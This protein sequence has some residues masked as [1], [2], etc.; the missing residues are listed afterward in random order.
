MIHQFCFMHQK[1]RHHSTTRRH[2]QAT[3]ATMTLPSNQESSSH[4]CST[5]S[6]TRT[7]TTK[8]VKFSEKVKARTTTHL[9]S[10][11]PEEKQAYWYTSDEIKE[12][13]EDIRA[14]LKLME[15]EMDLSSSQEFCTRGL[16]GQIREV[17]RRRSDKKRRIWLALLAEQEDQ[18]KRGRYSEQS[19]ADIYSAEVEESMMSALIIGLIDEQQERLYMPTLKDSKNLKKDCDSLAVISYDLRGGGDGRPSCSAAL[20]LLQSALHH[21]HMSTH[22]A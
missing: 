11:T 9:K 22:A 1:L 19:L 13:R 20:L 4:S 14:T 6:T 8:S 5:T 7:R 15:M 2:K 12:I 10:F 18:Y 3:T 17:A 21:R 16:E